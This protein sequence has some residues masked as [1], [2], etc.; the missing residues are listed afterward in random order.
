V[1]RAASC[2]EA[3]EFGVVDD[4]GGVTLDGIEDFFSE[5]RRRISWEKTFS[6]QA[7]GELVVY[8]GGD[9]DLGSRVID[10]PDEIQRCCA[11]AEL[12]RGR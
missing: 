5:K 12:A 7:M 1:S 4:T 8:F 9:G 3:C 2:E 6:G 10:A 11:A